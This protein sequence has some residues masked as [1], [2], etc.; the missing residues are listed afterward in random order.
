[1]RKA[2]TV[3]LCVGMLFSLQIW[4]SDGLDAKEYKKKS[5]E[6]AVECSI[7]GTWRTND[8]FATFIP[9]DYTG[10][11]FS[12]LSDNP[13]PEDPTVFGFFPMQPLLLRSVGSR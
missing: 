4:R 5:K 2:I 9:L 13:V 8:G 1:M 7:A 11:R 10:R 3:L 6:K 12:L